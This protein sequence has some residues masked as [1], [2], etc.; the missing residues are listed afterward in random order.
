MVKLRTLSPSTPRYMDKHTLGIDKMQ[1]PWL[2][3]LLRRTHLDELPQIFSVVAGSMSLVGPRPALPGD[4]EPISAEFESARRR[5]RPGCT[6]LWQL[7]TAST[8]TATSAPRFDLYYLRRASTRLDLWIIVRTVGWVLGRVKPIEIDDV[9]DWLLGP[10]LVSASDLVHRHPVPV[11][12]HAAADE[13]ELVGADSGRMGWTVDGA[14]P[15]SRPVGRSRET[16]HAV[17]A[18][19]PRENAPA[20]PVLVSDGIWARELI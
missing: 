16:R 12:A 5:V 18:R 4:V 8:D 3:S 6:G 2:C 7:S 1:L 9:P 13:R 14:K 10:G 11:D 17:R 19:Q 15:E 20:E